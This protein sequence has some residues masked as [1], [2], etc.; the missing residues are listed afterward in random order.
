MS[1]VISHQEPFALKV[2]VEDQIPRRA[3]FKSQ[4]RSFSTTEVETIEQVPE[5]W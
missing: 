1:A 2:A 3:A 5:A 4:W